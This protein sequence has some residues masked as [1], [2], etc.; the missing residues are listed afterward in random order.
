MDK[1][2]KLAGSLIK[3]HRE[4]LGMTQM[5]LCEWYLRSFPFE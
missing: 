3:Y 1:T 2:S 5:E 4:R